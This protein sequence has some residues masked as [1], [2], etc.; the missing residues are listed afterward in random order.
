[1]GRVPQAEI[2]AWPAT[3]A[4]RRRP[5]ATFR[6]QIDPRYKQNRPTLAQRRQA[7]RE[8]A[9]MASDPPALWLLPCG[10]VWPPLVASTTAED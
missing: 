7:A 10:P 4:R 2:P 6:T 1:M 3:S 8:R 9:F 5:V